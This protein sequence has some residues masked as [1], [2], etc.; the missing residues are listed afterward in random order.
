MKRFST[1]VAIL[2]LV[3]G[4]A[5]AKG[6]V[7]YQPEIDLGYS[8]GWGKYDP[9][10]INL[11]TIHGIQVSDYFSAG[12]GVGVDF[13]YNYDDSKVV[14]MPFYLNVKGYLPF[15]R[16]TSAYISCDTGWGVGVSDGIQK[17]NGI[18]ISPAIGVVWNKLKIQVGYNMQSLHCLDLKYIAL[19]S[20]QVRVGIMF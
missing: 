14:V 13:Y 10:S 18:T 4:V 15:A 1:L 3:A 9:E 8:I 11:H 6:F 16:K 5:G 17:T 7:S 19:N 12:L 20:L 2:S